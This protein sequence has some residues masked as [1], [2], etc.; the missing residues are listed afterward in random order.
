MRIENK[1]KYDYALF[2]SNMIFHFSVFKM[3]NLSLSLM[4][5]YISRC[6]ANESVECLCQ[7]EFWTRQHSLRDLISLDNITMEMD[8]EAW[9]AVR[10]ALP[11]YIQ[12]VVQVKKISVL[13]GIS[14]GT[15]ISNLVILL[16]II[17][18]QGKV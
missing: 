11:P 2:V 9:E 10:A 8:E 7:G 4:L 12:D 15:L 18:R 1:N 5:D 13:T 16:T 14:I 17:T 6:A 3:S